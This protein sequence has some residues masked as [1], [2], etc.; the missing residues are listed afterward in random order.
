MITAAVELIKPHR[1][2]GKD[3][4]AGDTV[5]VSNGDAQYLIERGIAKMAVTTKKTDVKVEVKD[6]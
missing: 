2:G 4:Q 5:T 1:H 6:E 3:Y